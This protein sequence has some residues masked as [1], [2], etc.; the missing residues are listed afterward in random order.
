MIWQVQIVLFSFMFLGL[1]L[2][3]LSVLSSLRKDTL[4]FLIVIARFPFCSVWLVNELQIVLVVVILYIHV[5][6]TRTINLSK[7][8]LNE[9]YC[10]LNYYAVVTCFVLVSGFIK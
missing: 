8:F 6:Y 2:S 3:S 10:L 9:H 7:F 1:N 5:C 4:L